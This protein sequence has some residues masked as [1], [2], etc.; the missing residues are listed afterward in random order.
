[1]STKNDMMLIGGEMGKNVT[2]GCGLEILAPRF[3]WL[4]RWNS[5]CGA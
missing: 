4:G 2:V 3:D 1:M 5:D